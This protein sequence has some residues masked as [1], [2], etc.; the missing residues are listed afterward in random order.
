MAR[1]SIEKQL[2]GAVRDDEVTIDTFSSPS[3]ITEAL[4]SRV[5][6]PAATLQSGVPLGRDDATALLQS[7]QK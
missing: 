6:A 7:L 5:V 1:R 3:Y 2:A 4:I